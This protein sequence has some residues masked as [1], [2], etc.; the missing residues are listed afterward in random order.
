MLRPSGKRYATTNLLSY[1]GVKIPAGYQTDGIS[2]KFR[3][4]GIFLNRF[5]PRYIHA[6]IF[7]DYIIEVMGDWELANRVFAELLPD[8]FTSK[9]MIKAVAL[10]RLVNQY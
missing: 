7:H 1:D 9:V 4:L 3:V 5:D 6:V 8:T 10:Y 2:Y